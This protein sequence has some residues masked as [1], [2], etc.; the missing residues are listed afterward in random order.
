MCARLSQVVPAALILSILVSAGCQPAGGV[1]LSLVPANKTLEEKTVMSEGYFA[2]RIAI[3]EVNGLLVDQQMNGLFTEGENPVSYIKEQLDKAKDDDRVKAV[4]LRV[5]SPG[6]T[7]TAS[8]MIHDEILRFKSK[9]GKPV[10]AIFTD[11][12]A[13]GAYYSAC[14]TDHIVAYPSSITGSIGVIMQ[15]FSLQGSLQALHMQTYAIKSGPFKDAG[16]PL[17]NL[18]P[19]E[20]EYFQTIVNQ[21]FGQFLDVVAKGRPNLTMD[22]I[23]ALANGKVYTAEQAKA[24]GLIDEIGS[25]YTAI[26]Y[27]KQKTHHPKMT[28]VTYHRPGQWKPTV[29]A[30]APTGEPGAAQAGPLSIDTKSLNDALRPKFLYLWAPGLTP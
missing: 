18:T 13:S 22:K 11:V 14:A 17:R 2:P 30:V 20:Q 28:V 8:Q 12:A 16:S 15:L 23:K 27:I 3:V 29:Y 24:D 21:F 25:I 19:E 6:G 9:S 5:N 1:K 26:D 10:V 4:L 7:V